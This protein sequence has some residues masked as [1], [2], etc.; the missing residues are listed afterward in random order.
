[1]TGVDQPVRIRSL[2]GLRAMAILGVVCGHWLTGALI[3]GPDGALSIHSPLSTLDWLR[4]S[5]WFFQMLGLFFLVG[6]YSAVLSI[7]RS[8]RRGIPDTQWIRARFA[9]LTRPV[10]AAAAIVAV[11]LPFAAVA[12]VPPGTLRGWVVLFVQPLWFIGVYLVITALTPYAL[13]LD[14][15]FGF[16]A[17][18]VLAAVVAVVD[19]V[20]Y[21]PW[22]E[23]VPGWFGY[24]TVLPAWMFTYQMGIAWARGRLRREHAIALL[25]GGVALFVLLIGLLDYPWS[26]VSVPG[27]ERSNS[28]PPSLLVPALAAVQTGAAFLLRD[29][30][31]RILHRPR[32]WAAVCLLNLSAMTVFC[33]HQT[34]LVAVSQVG[35]WLG[36]IPGLTDAPT[37]AGWVAARL[38]WFPILTLALAA[39]VVPLR[40]FEHVTNLPE[41]R[42]VRPAR[43]SVQSRAG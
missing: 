20:R 37:D 34:A 38:A 40:R 5:S 28:N 21:G 42:A 4:P 25:A 27:I 17:A 12:G 30:L 43:P 2:D 33:W 8:R 31:E 11:A 13:A 41:L 1:M 39:I 14:R 10:F 24:L 29:R 22:S 36:N 32:L 26:I 3:T 35:A 18:I 7:D 6:G 23:G 15:R 9:R 19:V 16:R